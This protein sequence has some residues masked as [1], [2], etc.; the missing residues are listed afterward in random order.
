MNVAD[1]FKQLPYLNPT[2]HNDGHRVNTAALTDAASTSVL[3]SDVD[4]CDTAALMA[5]T[6]SAAAASSVAMQATQTASGA[7]LVG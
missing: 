5:A 7:G 3:H 1:L 2:L 4:R 6:S